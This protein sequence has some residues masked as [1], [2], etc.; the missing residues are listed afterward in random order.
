MASHQMNNASSRGHSIFTIHFETY[1]NEDVTNVIQ[2]RL[3]L[4]DLAGSE[5]THKIG[6]ISAKVF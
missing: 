5:R 3:Q 4:I 2:S 6:N 1:N